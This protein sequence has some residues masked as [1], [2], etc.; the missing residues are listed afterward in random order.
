[1]VDSKLYIEKGAALTGANNI[2]T[3]IILYFRRLDYLGTLAVIFTAVI[4]TLVILRP[5]GRK[6]TE[7]HDGIDS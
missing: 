4:S 5:K 3:A 2:V 1:M 7:E 6:R